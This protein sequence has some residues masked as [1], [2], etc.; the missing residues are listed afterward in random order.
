MRLF[1]LHRDGRDAAAT[2]PLS[3]PMQVGR[4]AVEL[5]N[6]LGIAVF[7]DSD[8]VG[9][10][11]DIDSSGVEVDVLEMVR[12]ARHLGTGRT[13]R[14]LAVHRAALQNERWNVSEGGGPTRW[15]LS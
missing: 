1:Q 6:G 14:A 12:K 3:E 10:G 5:S 2:K 4:E 11:A 9:R 15:A 8:E 13:R 7:R